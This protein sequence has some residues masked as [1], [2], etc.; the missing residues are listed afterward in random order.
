MS[1]YIDIGIY[2]LMGSIS[3]VFLG[4]ICENVSPII[5][6]FIMSGVAILIFNILAIKNIKATYKTCWQNKLM[7]II[8]SGSLGID[9]ICQ[10]YAMHIS[11]PFVA[12][13]ATFTALAILG[14]IKLYLMHRRVSSLYSIG[15]LLISL[16]ILYFSY[17]INNSQNLGIGI[18][19]G[20][21]TGVTFFIYIVSSNHIIQL[22]NLTSLQL[23]STRF[24]LLF[25]GVA[26]FIPTKDLFKI[27]AHDLIAL[28]II[29][30]ASLIIPI[31]FNQQSIKK[32]G[33]AL[34]SIFAS[35]MPPVTY[36]F[37]AIYN[38]SFILSNAIVCGIITTSLILPK[39]ISL[40]HKES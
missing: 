26:F 27:S 5:A 10:I 17:Q 28:I 16:L 14:F 24:I 25:I 4:K 33:V 38:Q 7:F 13:A 6:L 21:C 22:G 3:F 34:S 2:I 30:F 39:I 19:L 8:M 31:Y 23:L 15:L 36:L 37:Y 9:W 11:D 32:L 29:S 40:I 1:G 35:L 12:S 18:I 20:I